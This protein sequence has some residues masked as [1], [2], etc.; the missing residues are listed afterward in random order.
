[1]IRAIQ[2]IILLFTVKL[3]Q[4]LAAQLGWTPEETNAFQEN[5]GTI[6]EF[7]VSW[8]VPAIGVVITSYYGKKFTK[9]EDPKDEK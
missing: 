6:V 3:G 2:V 7:A 1:M 9:K 4:L 5:L 8:A